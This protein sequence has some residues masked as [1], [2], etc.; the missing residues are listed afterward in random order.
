MTT[1]RKILIEHIHSLGFEDIREGVTLQRVTLQRLGCIDIPSYKFA[2]FAPSTSTGIRYNEIL[3]PCVNTGLL[4]S[5][6]IL[7]A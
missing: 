4:A 3:G 6:Y 2:M 1:R 7:N 5:N